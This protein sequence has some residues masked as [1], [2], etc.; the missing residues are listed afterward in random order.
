MSAKVFTNIR[1]ALECFFSF[2]NTQLFHAVEP[3]S[4]NAKSS[5]NDFSSLPQ[6][7]S[8]LVEID[9]LS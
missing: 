6:H 8:H 5:R 2:S 3:V 7:S 4:E 9:L 1:A